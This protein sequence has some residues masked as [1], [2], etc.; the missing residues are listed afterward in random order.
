MMRKLLRKAVPLLAACALV[1][2]TS[3]NAGAATIGV[4]VYNNYTPGPDGVPFSDFVGQLV[5]QDVNF[6]NWTPFGLTSFGAHVWGIL[7]ATENNGG[8]Q[9][10]MTANDGASLYIDGNHVLTGSGNFGTFPNGLPLWQS[11]PFPAHPF[12][13]FFYSNGVGAA[14]LVL[15]LPVGY[16][17]HGNP[18][19]VYYGDAPIPEPATLLLLGPA[20]LGLVARRRRQQ[21]KSSGK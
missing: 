8:Y 3:V 13:I 5:V 17:Q 4:D 18:D 10:S 1:A 7:L 11:P 20:A 2:G 12:D 16:D 6:L 19:G 14:N 9:F 15:N 21:G